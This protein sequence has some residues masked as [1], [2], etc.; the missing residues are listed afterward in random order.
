MGCGSG[1]WLYKAAQEGCTNL[2][3][4]DPF[5]ENEIHYGDRVH[6]KNCSIHE[7]DG[8]GTFDMIMMQDSFEHVTDPKEVLKSARR[9]LN[10]EGFLFISLPIFPN[11]AFDMYGPHWYALDAPRHIFLHSINSLNYLFD[12]C[13][14]S[15]TGLKYDAINSMLVFSFFYQ[16]GVPRKEITDVLINTYFPDE[17]I[18]QINDTVE[19]ANRNQRGDHIKMTLRKKF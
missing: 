5:L 9:L 3:G 18:L 16:H 4:C 7:M 2:F 8:D 13:G 14:F 15:I 19:K 12:E 17:Y 11:M 1:K 10:D 6:I